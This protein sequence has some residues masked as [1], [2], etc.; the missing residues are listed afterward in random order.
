MRAVVILM[1]LAL[2]GCGADGA[3][4]VTETSG[5]VTVGTHGVTTRTAVST[6]TGTVRLGLAL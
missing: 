3:P 5:S 4:F 1:G 6:T 2:A